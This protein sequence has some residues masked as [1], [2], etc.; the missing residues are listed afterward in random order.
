MRRIVILGSLL[1]LM[2]QLSAQTIQ[3]IDSVSFLMCD[4]IRANQGGEDRTVL[5]RIY[6]E[7]LYPYAQKQGASNAD[8]VSKQLYFRLQRNCVEFRNLLD[9][10]EP[11]KEAN[12][13]LSEKPTSEISKKDIREFKKREEFFYFEVLGDTTQVSIKEGIWQDTFQDGTYSRLKYD[14][15]SDS[16]FGLQF[17]V[18]NNETRANFSVEGD[19]YVYQLLSK[20]KGYYMLSVNIPGQEVY[21]IFRLYY[22]D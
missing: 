6:E 15:I 9:R 1:F 21:E 12:T 22:R 3:E 16:E 2:Q 13:R 11:P 18:S 17:I 4:F 10:L 5:D 19:L 14:W 8:R 20:E 7:Q